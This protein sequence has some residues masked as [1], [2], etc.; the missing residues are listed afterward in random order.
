MKILVLSDSHSD[1]SFMV[2]CVEKI[3]PDAII[4]LGDFVWDGENLAAKFP[5]IRIIQVAG[6]CDR[7]RVAPDYPTVR[8]ETLGGIRLFCTHGH[9]HGVKTY[10]DRLVADARRCNADIALYGHT[11]MYEIHQEE[12]GLW[13]VNPGSA[14][15]YG[16]T[17]ALITIRNPKDFTCSIIKQ[18]DWEE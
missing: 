2:R 6:N 8:I 14:G 12:D 13:V 15:S 5:E 18:R 16:G 10:L 9:L 7:Y 3:Q 17:A 11:H 4:H 1:D